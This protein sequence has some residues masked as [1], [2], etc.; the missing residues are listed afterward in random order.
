MWAITLRTRIKNAYKSIRLKFTL[1]YLLITVLAFACLGA[2][3]IR[4]VGVYVFTRAAEE[5][6]ELLNFISDD[7]NEA[8]AGGDSRTLWLES[9]RLSPPA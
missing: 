3:L 4:Q 5:K 8:Y 9:V 1:A 7:L 6:Q 2:A